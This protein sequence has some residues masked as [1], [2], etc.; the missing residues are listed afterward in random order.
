MGCQQ[1]V[2]YLGKG[3]LGEMGWMAIEASV[4]AIAKWGG[5]FSLQPDI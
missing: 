3:E 1:Q 4:Q 5:P 2:Q